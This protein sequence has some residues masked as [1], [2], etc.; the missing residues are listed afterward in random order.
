MGI[1][2]AVTERH[3]HICGYYRTQ[4]TGTK[5]M[6]EE[7]GHGGFTVRASHGY[8]LAIPKR[9]CSLGFRANLNG[10]RLYCS[11]YPG[12]ILSEARTINHQAEAGHNRLAEPIRCAV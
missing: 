12:M 4:A 2:Y 8:D 3:S 5:R 9:S 6:S 1:H 11:G 7:S 10:G